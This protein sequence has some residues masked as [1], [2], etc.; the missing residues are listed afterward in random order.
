MS[1]HTPGPWKYDPIYDDGS[2]LKQRLLPARII[3][4]HGDRHDVAE[5]TFCGVPS[6][7]D[8]CLIA[9][10]PELLEALKRCLEIMENGGRWTLEDQNAARAAIAKAKG[11]QS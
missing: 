11:E 8:A 10:A 1:K 9:T 3:S 4:C 7:A 6:Y 5:F 2:M